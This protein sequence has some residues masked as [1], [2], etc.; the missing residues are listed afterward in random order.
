MVR[1]VVL[2]DTHLR[3]GG[4]RRLPEGAYHLLAGAD[5]VLHAGD[6]VDGSVL[7]T[8]ESIAPTYAVL[9]NNDSALAGVLPTTRRLDLDGVAVAIIHDSGGREGRAR[10]LHRL[11]PDAQVVV[12]GHSH[13]PVD[14]PGLDGQLLFNPGSPTERR[15]SPHHTVGLLELERGAVTGHRIV[16]VDPGPPS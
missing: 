9:G 7:A 15:R 3:A 8:L 6:L 10:R 5:V 14:E 12:F 16:D 11:F 13:L 2:A 1:A 4:R